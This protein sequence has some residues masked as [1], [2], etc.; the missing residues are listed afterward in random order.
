MARILIV[1]D[2]G[3]IARDL[4]W[5][6]ESL[7]HTVPAIASTSEKALEAARRTQPDLVIMDVTLRGKHDGIE[8]ARQL[9]T[10]DPALQIIFLT[11]YTDPATRQRADAV[12]PI[13]YITKPYADHDLT[14][15]ITQAFETPTQARP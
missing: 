8:T 5:T 4:A 6:L 9:R 14:D 13:G 7:G 3:L 11:A 10:L 2:E 1:E 12:Q 15:L